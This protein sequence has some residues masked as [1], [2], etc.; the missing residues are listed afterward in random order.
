[1]SNKSFFEVVSYYKKN[2]I[3]LPKRQTQYSAGY[4]LAA[5]IEINIPPQ[6][7]AII[8]TGL[9]LFLPSNQVLLIY[10]RSS[11]FIKKKLM[12][13]NN[14]G[15]IDSDYY[16]NIE[17]EGHILIPLYNFSNQI[18]TIHKN[19]RIAQ[20]ILQNFLL[21]KNDNNENQIRKNGFGS[22]Q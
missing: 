18:I 7:I 8:P 19:E 22:T 16:N 20:G 17:N 4:D 1:M 21:T 5:A 3:Q 14:V 10:A 12:L 11:L 13:T 9:K 2:N 6:Q 15:V